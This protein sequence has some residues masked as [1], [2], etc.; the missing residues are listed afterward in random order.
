MT[1]P[2]GTQLKC[3]ATHVRLRGL[4]CLCDYFRVVFL[5]L[6]PES[7]FDG[8][9]VFSKI[10]TLT[11]VLNICCPKDRPLMN[12]MPDGDRQEKTDHS[13][14]RHALRETKH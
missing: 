14:Q 4:L 7:V 12:K 5:N 6:N 1:R 8:V 10:S 3:V 2:Q 13:T 9:K 11:E